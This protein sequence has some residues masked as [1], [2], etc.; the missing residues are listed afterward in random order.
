MA[1]FAL[2]DALVKIS[3]ASMSTF[4][5]MFILFGGGFI[6]FTLI[7]I[8]QGN[9]LV[10][11]RAFS[12][13]LL[14]R[15]V[16]EIAG[17][18]GMVTALATVPISTVGAITQA[19]PLVAAMGA[20]IFLKEKVG[21]RRWATIAVGFFGVLLIV[22][23]GTI[24]FDN[25]ILWAVLALIA[26]SAR[27]L[28]TRMIPTDLPSASLAAFTMAAAL[29]IT[30]ILVLS[31]GETLLPENPNWLLII[32]MIA[33]GS[34]GYML[35]IASIRMAEVSIVMPYRYSRILFLLMLGILVF[36]EKPNALMLMGAALVIVSGVYMLLREQ[37]VKQK[38]E[39]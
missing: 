31:N 19:S 29:P 16:A 34:F 21:W 3:T 25:S 15:Y 6:V 10:D 27:D 37:Q 8:Q 30:V 35:L 26:L 20:V 13:I 5:V 1:A 12:P 17:M 22:Q 14:F 11:R 32:P 2:A 23:P 38:T 18:V 36:D 7:A 33:L 28:N 39:G 9:K 4:Q 24:T